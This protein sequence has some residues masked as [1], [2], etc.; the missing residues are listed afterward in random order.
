VSM[1]SLTPPSN[2]VNQQSVTV[3]DEYS[4]KFDQGS[5]A[6]EEVA[7]ESDTPTASD[8]L[9]EINGQGKSLNINILLVIN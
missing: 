7:S 5:E 9:T 8:V 3:S 6:A 1:V 2:S 4:S